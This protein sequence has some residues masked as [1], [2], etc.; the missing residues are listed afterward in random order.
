MNTAGTV[1][2]DGGIR[3]WS[4]AF[5]DGGTSTSSNPTRTYA[6]AGTYTITVTVTDNWGRSTVTTREVTV[7]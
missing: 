3:S 2:N 7:T 1:D 5:G 4:W 6:A